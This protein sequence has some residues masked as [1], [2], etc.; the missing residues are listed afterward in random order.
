MFTLL[1]AGILTLAYG[2]FIAFTAL[3]EMR[4]QKIS[5]NSAALTG[6]TGL[7]I[8]FSALFI[9]FQIPSVFYILLIGLVAMHLSTLKNGKIT[10]KNQ[11][12]RLVISIIILSLT[13]IGIFAS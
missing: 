5:P 4:Q 13:F 11:I 6:F 7:I 10:S 9:P 12:I 2:A 3:K 8:M 1:L